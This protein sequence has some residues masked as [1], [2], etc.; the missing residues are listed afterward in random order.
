VSPP[1][2]ITGANG[3]IIDRNAFQRPRDQAL[4]MLD[5]IIGIYQG[6]IRFR[7][8]SGIS[9]RLPPAV[10]DKLRTALIRE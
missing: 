1:P 5:K 8:C 3:S 2:A 4:E 6:K 10:G 7:R 9:R